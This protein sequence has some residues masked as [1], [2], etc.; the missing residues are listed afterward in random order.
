M[1]KKKIEYEQGFGGNLYFEISDDCTVSYNDFKNLNWAIMPS[2][3][4]SD[5][6]RAETALVMDGEY[7]ILNGDFR[8]QYE[9]AFLKF[10]ND[11]AKIKAAVYDKYKDNND[12]SWSHKETASSSDGV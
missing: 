1:K 11:P 2:F 3:F 5:E 7:Y 12:S 9:K 8:K 4:G 6:G 10:G